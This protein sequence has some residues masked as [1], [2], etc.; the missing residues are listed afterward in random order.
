M[1]ENDEEREALID[2]LVAE[3]LTLR[4]ALLEK[5]VFSN[6]KTQD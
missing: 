3:N 2:E 4:H 6:A 1:Q 5:P